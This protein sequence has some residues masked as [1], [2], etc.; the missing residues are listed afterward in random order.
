MHL[1]NQA[2]LTVGA[3]LISAMSATAVCAE[4]DVK[5]GRR[6][7]IQCQACHGMDGLAKIPEAPNLAG[8]NP[9]YFRK[10]MQDYQSGARQNEM[11]TVVVQQLSAADITD[12][13]A[14]YGAIEITVTPPPR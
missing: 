14:Y 3:A 10:T 7:A 1:R 5:L 2:R 12:L 11:M 13:A 4:G 6:K 9:V 8:Q